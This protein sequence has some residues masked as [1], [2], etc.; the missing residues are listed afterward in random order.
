MLSGSS[1]NFRGSCSLKKNVIIFPL[2]EIDSKNEEN[3][4][5]KRSGLRR[6]NIANANRT[7]TKISRIF[8]LTYINLFG[9]RIVFSEVSDCLDCVLFSVEEFCSVESEVC[10]VP[11]D[12]FVCSV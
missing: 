6:R 3:C 12:V 2:L 11:E 7:S 9:F 4:P 8:A 10:S 5:L 1:D